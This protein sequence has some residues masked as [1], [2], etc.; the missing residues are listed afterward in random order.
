VIGMEDAV[1]V[2]AARTAVGTFGGVFT[3]VP[4]TR[5]G[6]IAIEEA[7]CRAGID[8]VDEVL[9]GNVLKAGLDSDTDSSSTR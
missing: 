4:A 8:T 6:S 7:L 5:L 1:I 3:D 2:S 9:M